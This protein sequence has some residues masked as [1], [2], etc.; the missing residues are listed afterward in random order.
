MPANKEVAIHVPKWQIK[1]NQL[2]LDPMAALSTFHGAIT[3]VDRTS[4]K[5]KWIVERLGNLIGQLCSI[6][7]LFFTLFSLS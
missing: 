2:V 4:L 3:L 6:P 5:K 1:K 7:L